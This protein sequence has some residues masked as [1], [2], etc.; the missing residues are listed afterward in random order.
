MPPVMSDV[1][2]LQYIVSQLRLITINKEVISSNSIQ[3]KQRHR[4]T[5][6]KIQ[7]PSSQCDASEGV[8]F[9]IANCPLKMSPS[10]AF[11][12]FELNSYFPNQFLR[13]LSSSEV[14]SVSSSPEA[15]SPSS[16]SSFCTK[17]TVIT[18]LILRKI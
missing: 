15:F 5:F 17:H 1:M 2:R 4:P 11:L 6:T 14:S 10:S 9:L 7:D 18:F 8:E 13:C 3:N 12:Y 16:L